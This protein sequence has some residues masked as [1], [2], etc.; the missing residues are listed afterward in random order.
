MKELNK[1]ARGDNSYG[2][3]LP[4]TIGIVK[5]N[6]DPAHHG[7]LQ[8]F[9]PTLDSEDFNV[10][11]LPW[12]I[13]VSPFGGVTANPVVGREGT[14]VPGLTSYGTWAIPK[15]GAQVLIGFLDGN[16]EMRF[17]AGCVFMPEY[18]RTLPGYVNGTHT[19]LDD[20]GLYPQQE[21][22]TRNMEDAGLEE[23]SKHFKTRGPY[24]RSVSH[25]SNKNKNKPT[26]NGYAP[27][28]LDSSVADSQTFVPMSTPG[29]HYVVMSDVDEY[30]RVRLKTTAGSQII[31]DD[32]NE[33]IYIS[34]AKGRSWI[35]LDETNGRI[36]MYSD[37]KINV[38]AKNDLNL[39]SDENINIVAK[40]RVNIV[41]EE[42]GVAIQGKQDVT[43][44]SSQ[45]N[46][47][48]SASRDLALTTFNGPRA[49]AQAK[50]E[51]SDAPGWHEN[52]VGKGYIYR[53]A[54]GGGA[55]TSSIKLTSAQTIEA[56]AADAIAVSS[57]QSLNLMGSD[58]KLG[59]G[60][61]HH[62]A[63]AVTWNVGDTG[64]NDGDPEGPFQVQPNG[65]ASSP[66]G[67]I[68]AS[69]VAAEDVSSHL[70]KPN[71]ESWTRDEDEK[72]TP[73]PRGPKYQG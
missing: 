2:Q 12:A 9:I 58:I 49:P 5:N 30:C 7:R 36:Y 3:Q 43:I 47:R 32:T 38:R 44:L 27:N 73:T 22:D 8:V 33:R 67:A 34:T 24:E 54:Q 20:S 68:P 15:N 14:K 51:L 13:Y 25:P 66:R 11:D 60:T 4:F 37:S 35:E 62:V 52:P 53:F 69:N 40:Q 50:Q 71:H 45:A 29:G 61:I 46:V 57:A 16:P 59:A 41:S 6:A 42:R 18:N 19:E 26:D 39:Y 70:I 17:W 10:A 72:R 1:I 64:L 31:L 28:P 48:I 21:I 63:G 56:S 23:G 65:G 55:G